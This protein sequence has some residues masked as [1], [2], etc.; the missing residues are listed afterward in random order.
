MQA[1]CYNLVT[2]MWCGS[3]DNKGILVNF[4]CYFAIFLFIYIRNSFCVERSSYYFYT[5][6]MATAIFAKDAYQIH[7]KTSASNYCIPQIT[8]SSIAINCICTWFS[9]SL[10]LVNIK[11]H[12]VPYQQRTFHI[13]FHIVCLPRCSNSR[14]K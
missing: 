13:F 5:L 14:K 2:L 7:I 3:L 4:M 1:S 11:V 10:H 8:S 9:I 6:Y 12:Q